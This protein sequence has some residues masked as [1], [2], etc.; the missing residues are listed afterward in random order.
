MITRMPRR[1]RVAIVA[2]ATSGTLLAMLLLAGPAALTAQAAGSALAGPT[3]TVAR[4]TT[5]AQSSG[6]TFSE[7]YPGEFPGGG[8]AILITIRPY[9]GAPG[10]I[11]FDQASAPVFDGP[12]SLGGSGHFEG[13]RTLKVEIESTNPA[14]LE[15]FS[16]TGLRLKASETCGLGPVLV[17][18]TNPGFDG[19]FGALPSIAT[20]G[21]TMPTPS[22][23]PT[24]SPSPTT[25]PSPSPEPTATPPHI[26]VTT[27]AARVAAGRPGAYTT[28]FRAR[29]VVSQGSRV[30]VR[31]TV[32]PTDAGRGVSLYRRYGTSGTWRL[33]TSV[34]LDASGNATVGTRVA[35]PSTWSGS[36]QVQYRWFLSATSTATAAWSDVAR[37]AVR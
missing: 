20:A 35:L 25:S 6:W 26:V 3:L 7:S 21:G 31:A 33:I 29:I 8:F 15:S 32:R 9:S 2:A 34:R 30:T 13:P 5:S 14:Q 22:P 10:G 37:V 12:S 16:V 4:G 24:R 11:S 27:A 1:P 17:S 28:S 36:R 23:T 19:N 18:Y